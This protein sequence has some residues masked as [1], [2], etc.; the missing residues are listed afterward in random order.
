MSGLLRNRILHGDALTRL[1][2]L[3]SGSVDVCICSPPF[4]GVR[5]Y[6]VDGQ[7][8]LEATVQQ[9]VANLSAVFAEVARVLKPTGSLWVD[10]A[11]SYSRHPRYGAPAKGLLLAPERLTPALAEAGWIIRNKNIWARTNPRPHSV[12]DRFICTYDLLLF[13]VRSRRYYF[14]L[15]DVRVPAK[16]TAPRYQ[17]EAWAGPLAPP[18][19][20][21]HQA[22][23][24]GITAHPLG[25]NP[26]D[27]WRLPTRS[28]RGAHF[29]TFPPALIER[30]MLAT[31]PERVCAACAVPRERAAARRPPRTP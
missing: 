13:A 24:L 2:G 8:G 25:K 19:G 5:D 10:L 6:A 16:V 30:P 11:D 20:W 31:C 18:I 3:P 9:W 4:Y 26:G 27:V 23:A 1:R 28:F 14:S 22:R 7:L 21:L 17:R 15:D 12:R 29:A